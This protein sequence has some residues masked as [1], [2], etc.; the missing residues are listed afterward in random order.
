MTEFTPLLLYQ[1]FITG[2]FAVFAGTLV[3]NLVDIKRL[4]KPVNTGD[5]GGQL[6]TVSLLVPAR[7][8]EANIE[9]CVRSLLA[10]TY[11]AV[12]VIVLNDNS[13]DATG[14]ILGRLQSETP[15]LKVL[16]G[17]ALPQGWLGKCWACQQL[18][19][20][21][22]GDFLLFTDADTAHAP[23][24][25]TRCLAAMER[26]RADMLTLITHQEMESFWERT[27]I[28]LIHFFVLC[29]LPVRFIWT[30]P[31]TL[32]AF[33][34]GQ[35]LLFRRSRYEAIGGHRAVKSAI[36]E[37]VWLAKAVKKSG[38]TVRV[39]DGT[40]A[41]Q[42]RMYRSFGEVWRGFSKNL[43][44]GLGYNTVAMTLLSVACTALYL[45][46]YAFVAGAIF[47]QHLTAE[48]FYF[49]LLHIA[50]AAL[51]RLA[52]A[53][54]FRLSIPE[55]FLHAVSIGLFLGIAFNSVRWIKSGKGALWKGRRYDFSKASS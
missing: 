32:F 2:C 27:V 48:A 21:A 52:I 10:Q 47:T 39:Y 1:L 23:E 46:P 14:E 12:E 30:N 18:A 35:F 7:N 43:F 36:V 22:Q 15:R 20:A 28:P 24:T 42:C 41:V 37:D 5:T 53:L 26:T 33:A 38:G 11:S 13:E 54:R 19:D 17:T 45:I 49:P 9:R 4:P 29:Y 3:L 16:N 34:N 55:A 8:E 50:L 31:S 6:P 51:L 40:D 44:A 25:L